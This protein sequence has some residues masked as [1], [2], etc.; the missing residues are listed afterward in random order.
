MPCLID[1]GAD[2]SVMPFTRAANILP[3]SIKLFAVNGTPIKV[4]GQKSIKLDLGLRREF[5][6]TFIIADVST[7]ILGADFLRNF[8]LLI[9]LKRNRLI[10][11]VT[12]LSSN[13]AKEHTDPSLS[14]KTFIAS[15]PYADLLSEFESITR[16][17]L[18]GAIANATVMHHIDTAGP[19]IYARP[20]RLPADKL[21]AARAEFEF[22]MKAGIC[23]PSKSNWA[24]P[25]H[26][27]KKSDLW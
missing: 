15:S 25:L 10:D 17:P 19:P 7:H 18:P 9:D 1:S 27:V 12:Q 6:W 21:E 3:T 13:C 14:I 11:N 2:V 24:S 22:L 26:M 5:S 23:R 20:R 4:Y 8:D 16:L